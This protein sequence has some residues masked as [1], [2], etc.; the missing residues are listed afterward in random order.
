MQMGAHSCDTHKATPTEMSDTQIKYIRPTSVHPPPPVDSPAHQRWTLCRVSQGTQGV[1]VCCPI[2][3]PLRTGSLVWYM[4]PPPPPPPAHTGQRRST[5][6]GQHPSPERPLQGAASPGGPKGQGQGGGGGGRGTGQ[7]RRRNTAHGTVG[8]WS[9]NTTGPV[10]GPAA[11][12]RCV[13]HDMPLYPRGLC[14][15]SPMSDV[16]KGPLR[17]SRSW[18]DEGEGQRWQGSPT[19]NCIPL[20]PSRPSHT[21]ATA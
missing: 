10:A 13:T 8:V 5:I 15:T 19:H 3:A 7:T 9:K 20:P 4:P 17:T 12:R 18:G 6:G 2:T 21:Q 16:G 11:H 1:A 14:D